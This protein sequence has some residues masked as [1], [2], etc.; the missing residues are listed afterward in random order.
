MTGRSS[1]RTARPTNVPAVDLTEFLTARLT[2]KEGRAR[3]LEAAYAR[4]EVR[5]G[6][7]VVNAGALVIPARMLAECAAKRRIVE[8]HVR[9]AKDG[10]ICPSSRGDGTLWS[11]LDDPACDTLRLLAL[12]Y[13]DHSDYREEWRP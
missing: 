5:V 3:E 9:S 6:A 2:D 8:L 11:F 12:P 13:A 4:D 7:S 1:T 10:H